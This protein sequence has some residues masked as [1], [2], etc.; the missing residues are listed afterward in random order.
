MQWPPK[1]CACD[2]WA[3]PD[4]RKTDRSKHTLYTADCMSW[5]GPQS[6]KEQHTCSCGD[7]PYG[8]C[9]NTLP[10]EQ[11]KLRAGKGGVWQI[12]PS[13]DGLA[14]PASALYRFDRRRRAA[15]R[16]C[17]S[18]HGQGCFIACWFPGGNVAVA[19]N[20]LLSHLVSNALASSGGFE[21]G[22]VPSSG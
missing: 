20:P 11:T 5:L 14:L 22:R 21:V 16:R 2:R 9:T 1:F 4:K 19:S 10:K 8:P 12:P 17:F 3:L 7:P 15:L 18:R 6:E 13:F